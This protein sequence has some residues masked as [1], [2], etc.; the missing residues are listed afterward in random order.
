MEDDFA[1]VIALV[2]VVL[3]VALVVRDRDAR[4]QARRSGPVRGRVL[5]VNREEHRTRTAS[6]RVTTVY[7]VPGHTDLLHH[8]R[9]FEDEGPALLWARL[10]REGSEHDVFPNTREPGTAFVAE[11][12][13]GSDSVLVLV[14]VVMAVIVLA[15]LGA[16]LVETFR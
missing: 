3:G 7:E 10:H 6:W 11:D 16:F 4:I 5:T 9:L 13:R 14:V 8:R 15:A 1:L 2:S 12:L